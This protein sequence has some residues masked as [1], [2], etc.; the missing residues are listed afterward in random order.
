VGTANIILN[1]TI[2][3]LLFIYASC[4]FSQP[5]TD[6]AAG[7]DAVLIGSP[8]SFTSRTQGMQIDLSIVQWL[9]AAPSPVPSSLQV[10]ATTTAS[11]QQ[12]PAAP[13]KSI[14]GIWFLKSQG[15]G[16]YA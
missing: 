5:I 4:A 8:T 6:L 3:S 14:M 7:S 11:P 16:T 1:R 13:V 2:N 10:L 12:P 9:S 15:D